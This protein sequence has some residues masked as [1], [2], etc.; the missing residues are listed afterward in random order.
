MTHSDPGLPET[1]PRT[2]SLY[3]ANYHWRSTTRKPGKKTIAAR[4]KLDPLMEGKS[5]LNLRHKM[6]RSFS[7]FWHAHRLHGH[8][9][10]RLRWAV[11][12]SWYVRQI[13]IFRDLK[14]TPITIFIKIKTTAVL[15]PRFVSRY[16]RRSAR[17]WRLGSITWRKEE[18]L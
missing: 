7:Q 3:T 15:R 13:V 4:T 5:R 18:I 17:C 1:W 11:D 10:I 8:E 14:Q 2:T 9:N 12:A 16:R 6:T